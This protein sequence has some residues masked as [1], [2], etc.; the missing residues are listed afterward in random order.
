[1]AQL[2]IRKR[3]NGDVAILDLDGRLT[4][5]EGSVT[6][7]ESVRALLADGSK[8]ILVN[9]A[10]VDYVDSSGLGEIVSA[11]ATA[12]REDTTLKLLN[13]TERVHGL[14]QMTKLL[15][16]FET[17][18]TEQDAVRSFDAVASMRTSTSTGS[19]SPRPL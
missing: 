1:M 7:R 4:M 2:Q 8:H 14:L 11:F 6:L 13:L 5:G 19:E 15:T 9:L 17:F 3:M 12:K 16:I 18:E 10:G